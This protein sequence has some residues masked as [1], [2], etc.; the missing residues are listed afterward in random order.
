MSKTADIL[1]NTFLPKRLALL[2]PKQLIAL[3]FGLWMVAK[4]SGVQTEDLEA[5]LTYIE[6][7]KKLRK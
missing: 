3:S 4:K 5:M 6:E 1:D 7:E 2:H